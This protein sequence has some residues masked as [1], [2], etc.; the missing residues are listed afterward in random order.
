MRNIRHLG[1]G[2]ETVVEWATIGRFRLES[3]HREVLWGGRDDAGLQH[4]GSTILASVE[5]VG[6]RGCVQGERLRGCTNHILVLRHGRT[7]EHTTQFFFRRRCRD[8]WFFIF[9]V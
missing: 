6:L 4:Q 8:L 5:V 1:E 9:F 7:L 3:W 2:G